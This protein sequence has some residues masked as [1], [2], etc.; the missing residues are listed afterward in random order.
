MVDNLAEAVAAQLHGHGDGG[1]GHAV[2]RLR[3]HEPD[4][5]ERTTWHTLASW[6]KGKG[7]V[8]RFG[9]KSQEEEELKGWGAERTTQKLLALY[10][11]RYMAL[12]WALY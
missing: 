3:S 10:W 12:Y 1:V 8:L 2:R 4:L 5:H 11:A 7:M 6:R 9:P